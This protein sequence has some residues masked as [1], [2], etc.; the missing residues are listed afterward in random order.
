[1]QR[2]STDVQITSQLHDKGHFTVGVI[3]IEDP[4]VTVKYRA[5]IKVVS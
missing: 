5:A 1:M 3:I 4:A 2:L